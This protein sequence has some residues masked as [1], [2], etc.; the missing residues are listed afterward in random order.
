[1]SWLEIRVLPGSDRDAILAALFAA[2]SQGVHEEG[3]SLIT[4]FPSTTDIEGLRTLLAVAGPTA[5][6]TVSDTP[7]V[8]WTVAWKG[9]I[10]RHSLGS[11]TVGPPWLT[12]NLDPATTVIIEPGMGFGTG[13]HETTRGV[14]RLMQRAIREGDVVADLGA[15]SAVLSIA[16]ARLGASR[17]LAIEI[18]PD[19]IGNAEDNVLRNRVEAIV[20]VVEGDAALLL[21]LVAPLRVVLANIISS[22]LIELL[23]VIAR[24]LAAGGCAILSG[25]LVEE[26]DRMLRHLDIEGWRVVDEDQE[27]LWWSVLI[28]RR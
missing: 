27:A 20:H 10:G 19:A 11:L 23:P 26:R 16:A 7:D 3:A 18:D 25:L 1:M 28:E 2:G 12:G 17:V 8:D 21:P 22:V 14:V 5:T 4:H 6:V 24:S 15:G 9:R 13:E